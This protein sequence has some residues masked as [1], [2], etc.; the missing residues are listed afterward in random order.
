MSASTYDAGFMDPP[1]FMCV[2][3]GGSWPCTKHLCVLPTHAPKP[4]LCPCGL[5]LHYSSASSRA[6]V[7]AVIAEKGPVVTV[8]IMGGRTFKVPR[9]Y[10][11]LH[12]FKASEINELAAKY[13][14]EEVVS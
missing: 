8:A 6:H 14:F 9:H 10:I 1:E 4:V 3:C 12:G 13:G 11:A 2:A 7:E 5:P